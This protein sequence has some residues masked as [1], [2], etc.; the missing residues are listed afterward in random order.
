MSFL[1]RAPAWK[2]W[3]CGLLLLATTVN[4]M[5]RLTLNLQTT[6]IKKEFGFDD[7]GYGML[8]AAFGSAFALGAI[9]MGWSADRINVRWL[10]ALSVLLWSMAGLATGFVWDFYGLLLCRF[11]LGFAEAGNWPCALRTTQHILPPEQRTF[12]NSI[13][14]SGAAI[15]A[16]LTPLLI[17]WMTPAYWQTTFILVGLLGFAWVAFWLSSVRTADLAVTSTPS[18]RSLMEI[19]GWLV[20]LLAFDIWV[21]LNVSAPWPLVSKA[22]TTILGIVIVARWLILAT[23]DDDSLP[24]GLFLRR[25]LALALTV[26]AI[27]LTW[28]F[29]RAWLSPFLQH[30]HHYTEEGAADFALFYYLATD[31]GSLTAGFLVLSLAASLGV[32]NSRLV[33]YAGCALLTL[34]SFLAARFPANGLLEASLLVIGFGALGLFPIY[35]ALSQELTR[36]NQGKLTGALGCI[37][38][39][40]MSLL[41]EVVGDTV[42]RTQSYSLGVTLA[43]C[44]PLIG[45]AALLLLWGKTPDSVPLPTDVGS[46]FDPL[47]VSASVQD[48]TEALKE[49]GQVAEPR[50]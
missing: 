45:L 50:V 29:F 16:I 20:A 34:F 23:V 26:V 18:S 10:Y 46:H 24:R 6:T 44:A 5:D 19:L 1:A 25:F 33:V 38:W 39:L 43:G 36:K 14:Q 3:V 7:A 30:A 47:R 13:L 40:T 17:R 4:Y 37:C 27:N 31:A 22:L 32:H 21:H 41:Q 48:A 15:G 9:V 42:K 12:G 8:E 49:P 2:W 35:Y 28:H 11:A